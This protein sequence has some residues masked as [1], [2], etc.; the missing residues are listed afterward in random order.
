MPPSMI[1]RVP[2][3]VGI[4]SEAHQ[5]E[6]QPEGHP[7]GDG[8][9]AQADEEQSSHMPVIGALGR[10]LAVG[11]RRVVR[12]LSAALGGLGVVAGDHVAAALAP[13]AGDRLRGAAQARDDAARATARRAG[14]RL[15]LGGGGVLVG[16][17][18]L[19]VT[20]TIRS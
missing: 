8:R 10:R 3:A 6:E 11:L 18:R 19:R 20:G 9:P 16:H 2:A 5:D 13:G 17:W 14:P 12:R 4:A 1:N 15:G 7:G